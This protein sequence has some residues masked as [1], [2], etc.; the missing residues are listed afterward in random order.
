MNI[1]ENNTETHYQAV[2][3]DECDEENLLNDTNSGME[4]P[5]LVTAGESAD[6]MSEDI[7]LAAAHEGSSSH[8]SQEVDG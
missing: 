5:P 6:E 1:S 7:R 3:E 8:H 4:R 2:L